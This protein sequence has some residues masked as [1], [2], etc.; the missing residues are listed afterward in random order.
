MS[1]LYG[2]GD[3]VV[4]ALDDIDVD[5]VR[6]HF[7]AIMGPSGSGKSTLMHCLAAGGVRCPIAA[8]EAAVDPVLPPPDPVAFLFLRP[9]A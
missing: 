4:R 7:T 2:S 5:F 8:H 6:G 1:K 9:A 3:T